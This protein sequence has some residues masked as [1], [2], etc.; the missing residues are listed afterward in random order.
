MEAQQQAASTADATSVGPDI[1]ALFLEHREAMYRVAYHMLRTDPHHRAE[2]VIGEVM[3]SLVKNPPRNQVRNWQ[4]FLVEAV[5]NKVKDHW[6]SA[7]QRHELLVIEDVVPL[8]HEPHGGDQLDHD[9]APGV[10]DLVD[11]Q[12]RAQVVREA[13]DE[14]KAWDVQAAY[15]LWQCTAMERTSQ[16]VA[17]EL[18]VSSSRVRQIA[19]KA[20]Q[21]MTKILKAKE[22]NL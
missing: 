14:L 18:G 5:K 9:P 13:M 19:L 6:K 21:E 15:V 22:V 12:Q 20:R 3:M 17:A 1:G 11:G 2:D 16:D 8:D 4:A 10:V 7:A